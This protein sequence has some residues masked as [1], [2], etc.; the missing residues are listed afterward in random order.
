MRSVLYNNTLDQYR[1]YYYHWI[2]VIIFLL[3]A[4]AYALWS[5]S[6]ADNYRIT[7]DFFLWGVEIVALVMATIVGFL[8]NARLKSTYTHVLHARNMSYQKLFVT[9]WLTGMVMIVAVLLIACILWTVYSQRYAQLWWATVRIFVYIWLKIVLLYS[10]LYTVLVR[11]KKYLASILVWVVYIFLYSIPT[12]QTA[13]YQHGS[14]VWIVLVDIVAF[15][16]PTFINN[17]VHTSYIYWLSSNIFSIAISHGIYILILL[18]VW[19]LSY[20]R[21]RWK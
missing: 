9:H 20:T 17:S 14:K 16:L 5:L 2:V 11:S 12:I 21:L 6:P 3:F 19:V 4:F 10:F 1:Q 18:L 15:L 13:A 8:A 7:A